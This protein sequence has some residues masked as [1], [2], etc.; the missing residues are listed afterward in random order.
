MIEYLIFKTNDSKMKLKNIVIFAV[1]TFAFC[2]AY[3]QDTIVQW[4][5]NYGGT[6][7]EF[8]YSILNT[9]EGGFI[10]CGWTQSGD[11]DIKFN[12]GT[13][14]GWI[15]KIRRDSSIEW[16][17]TYGGSDLDQFRGMLATH[18][19]G[20]V[21]CGYSSSADDDL[22]GIY[23]ND[24]SLI[25]V[26][27]I[28]KD[29]SI[30]WQKTYAGNAANSITSTPDGG[31][32][33]SGLANPTSGHSL[34]YD[35]RILKLK[36]D[37][38]VEWEKT[39]GGTDDDQPFSIINSLD[40]GY[41]MI[42]KT[43]SKELDPSNF[44]GGLYDLWV[45][46]LK[47]NGDIDW[48]KVYGGSE[49][50]Y[51]HG[52]GNS[53]SNFI[54]VGRTESIDGAVTYN[55]GGEDVWVLKIDT[56]GSIVWQKTFGGSG[57]DVVDIF[58]FSKDQYL[59]GGTTTSVDGDVENI[60]SGN[61]AWILAIKDSVIVW[62]K[63]F[64]SS[65]VSPDASVLT[66]T[67][68]GGLIFGG[69][70]F[71]NALRQSS[72]HGNWDIG[73][74]KLAGHWKPSILQN[75]GCLPHSVKLTTSTPIFNDDSL[76][77]SWDLGDGKGYVSGGDTVYTPKYTSA[78]TYK[79]KLRVT[80]NRYG[81]V[82]TVLSEDSIVI[83]VTGKA[84]STPSILVK[85]KDTL[86]SSYMGDSCEWY[87]ND[88]LVSKGKC[89]YVANQ[90][91]VYKVVVDSGGC[92]SP[93]SAGYNFIYTGIESGDLDNLFSLRPN[94]TNS[95]LYF[96]Q[97]PPTPFKGG[98]AQARA[99]ITDMNGRMLLSGEIT[100][101]ETSFD[102]STLPSGIYLFRYQDADRVWNGKFVKE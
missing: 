6:N 24:S 2:N 41:V 77:I 33:L 49:D 81:Y 94:P 80:N 40:S 67:P 10:Y 38:T 19:S 16:E 54:L 102:V 70:S 7:D 75:S 20:Y 13:L 22:L 53:D 48:Q 95:R 8:V 93:M 88:T 9:P 28:K 32:I 100:S 3:A 43:A 47:N 23:Q 37:G 50:E 68:D 96:T 85:G 72:F 11:G 63:A 58:Q 101:G 56:K 55:H 12:H 69:I 17:K 42:G 98:L 35:T 91:G 60:S 31:Y 26:V 52:I 27:K 59:A 30:E 46:K 89:Q 90:S 61:K 21:L 39:Y 84:P 62:Q 5:K 14:D 87:R 15:V 64:D 36:K 73:I 86:V 44:Y 51:P 66:P 65:A 71:Y 76:S 82:G 78:G 83:A 29:G 45:L 99:S 79:V 1:L 74:V 25:W 18:D 57:D 34:L 4:Q 97:H 92:P